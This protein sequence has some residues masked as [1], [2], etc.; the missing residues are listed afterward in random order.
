M[1][2][3][4]PR[5]ATNDPQGAGDDVPSPCI[6]VCRLD[7][8]TRLCEGC[9]RTLDEIA[10]WSGYTRAEKFAVRARVDA[11]QRAAGR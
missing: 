1:S 5:V 7:E 6:N 2:A 3:S 9:F 10:C 11:R 4:T 8:T